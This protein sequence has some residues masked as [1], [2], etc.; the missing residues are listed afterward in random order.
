MIRRPPRST[1][2][3][4]LFPYTTLFRA[5]AAEAIE[6][7]AARRVGKAGEQPG[8]AGEV[9]IV[10]AGLV[11]AA[12]DDVVEVGPVHTRIAVDQRLDRAGGATVG[13]DLG[14][15]TAIAADRG[16]G[17]GANKGLG[18]STTPA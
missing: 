18:H 3:D 10:L 15:R 17:G 5:G 11:G 12:E 4:T 14:E 16:A 13:A 2:T 8:H 6:R 9:A 1:R 7:D